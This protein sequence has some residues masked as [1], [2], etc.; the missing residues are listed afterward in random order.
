MWTGARRSDMRTIQTIPQRLGALDWDGVQES[1]ARDGYVMT[2]PL[3]AAD[4]CAELTSLYEQD[5]KF[6]SQIVMSRF[7]FGR[8]EYKYFNNPLPK[9]VSELREAAYPKLASI[10]NIW[11][12]QIGG[13]SFPESYP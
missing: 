1:L 6:R 9:L 10:A 11:A 13:P 7:G 5:S 12:G 2:P 3:L 8:G 4:E